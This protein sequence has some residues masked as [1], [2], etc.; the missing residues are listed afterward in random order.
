M[1]FTGYKTAKEEMFSGSYTAAVEPEKTKNHLTK[2]TGNNEWYTPSEYIAAA[3]LVLGCIDLDPAS[4]AVANKQVQAKTFFTEE[5]D[6]LSRVWPKGSIWMNPPYAKP[7]MGQ[8]VERFIQEMGAGSTGIVLVN[9]A[10]ETTW[11]QSLAHESSAICFP[12]SRVRFLDSQGNPKNAPLQ[13]QAVLYCGK[14]T[15]AFKEAFSSFGLV[16]LN[17]KQRERV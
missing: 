6:G 10:T 2:N 3:R 4:C 17:D 5:M 11:F 13:G 8:F 14:K 12:K 9:N 16:V 7:L 15:E 1:D